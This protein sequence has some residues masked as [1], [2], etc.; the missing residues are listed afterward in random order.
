MIE[1]DF[2]QHACD[3]FELGQIED[4]TQL[5]G[6]RTHLVYR[7]KT[8]N[9]AY[10]IKDLQSRHEKEINFDLFRNTTALAYVMRKNTLPAV[11][12][13]IKNDDVVFVE[14]QH[15][16]MVYHYVNAR[17]IKRSDMTV[18]QCE[19]IAE[20]I[21]KMHS[22]NLDVPAA[23]CWNYRYKSDVWKA[24]FNFLEEQHIFSL[25]PM[26][27]RLNDRIRAV[28]SKY[29]ELKATI[30]EDVVIGHRDIDA[31]NVLWSS[32]KN[33]VVIDWDCAGQIDAAVELM[34]VAIDFAHVGHLEFDLDKFKGI[35]T[36]Y[37]VAREIK[38][39]AFKPLFYTVI[40]NWLNWCQD[41]LYLLTSVDNDLVTINS[42][43]VSVRH[44]LEA[45]EYMLSIEDQFDAAWQQIVRG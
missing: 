34:Y 44:S 10:I 19:L 13:L 5:K 6:G 30:E 43:V 1:L 8:H 32:E 27:Q 45:F 39:K 7:V 15:A 16:F 35:V 41:R 21:A 11:P 9:G 42:L 37:Q 40:T 14:K 22:L 38:T 3:F 36:A 23:P 31:Y 26:L 18:T 17:L 28:F 25:A 24:A 20:F 33:F 4:A 29:I 12:A 2:L